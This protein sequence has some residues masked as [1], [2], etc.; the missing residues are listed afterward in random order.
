MI[1]AIPGLLLSLVGIIAVGAVQFFKTALDIAETNGQI[2]LI[3]K[4]QLQ[5]AKTAQKVSF[6][7]PPTPSETADVAKTD[8]GATAA[9]EPETKP[10]PPP[11][12]TRKAEPQETRP[13]AS[14]EE[15]IEHKGETIGIANGKALWGDQSFDTVDTAKEHINATEGNGRL[16]PIVASFDEKPPLVAERKIP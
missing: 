11:G 14:Y 2:L 6:S 1:G 10:A 8:H 9:S 5:L 7:P 13:I 4:E 15:K 12:E 3:T 16:E